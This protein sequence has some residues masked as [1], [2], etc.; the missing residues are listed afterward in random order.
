MGR[1]SRV[2]GL[3]ELHLAIREVG[4]SIGSDGRANID[5]II[6]LLGSLRMSNVAKQLTE[7][8]GIPG[9]GIQIQTAILIRIG[10]LLRIRL[11]LLHGLKKGMLQI[12]IDKVIGS[13]VAVV[14]NARH[15]CYRGRGRIRA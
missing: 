3:V 2:G 6:G 7:L 5:I 9:G 15:R 10:L 1:C 11:L 12:I 14:H 8:V 13:I 4:V